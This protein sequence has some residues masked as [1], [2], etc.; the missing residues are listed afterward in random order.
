LYS[1]A[2]LLFAPSHLSFDI[3]VFPAVPGLKPQSAV[4]P[5]LALGDFVEW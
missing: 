2:V 5:Q 1:A 4:G 3:V